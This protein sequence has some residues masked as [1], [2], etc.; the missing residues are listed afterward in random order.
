ME[1]LHRHINSRFDNGYTICQSELCH[2]H[3]A[4]DHIHEWSEC[5]PWCKQS[6]VLIACWTQS[7][8]LCHKWSE[9]FSFALCSRDMKWS[10]TVQAYQSASKA[11]APLGM[12]VANCLPWHKSHDGV[13]SKRI[14]DARTSLIIRSDSLWIDCI[15]CISSCVCVN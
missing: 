1:I 15:S 6:K 4:S 8:S 9:V 12:S 13:H 14:A 5:S 2:G 3:F 11:R 7:C 10:T